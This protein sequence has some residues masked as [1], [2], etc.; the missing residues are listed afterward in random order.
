MLKEQVI[1]IYYNL[2]ATSFNITNMQVNIQVY[3]IDL[4]MIDLNDS[5]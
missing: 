1:Y 5:I 2:S 4:N 3:V